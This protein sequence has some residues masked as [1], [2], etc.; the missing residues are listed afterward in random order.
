MIKWLDVLNFA[1]NGNPIPPRRVEKTDTE[2]KE[3]L[4]EEQY[5]ITRT[6][7]TERPFSG[8]FCEALEPGLYECVCCETK[9]FDSAEKFNSKSGWPSFTQPVE[10]EAVKYKKDKSF[11]M[12]RVEAM[13]NVCDA[14]LGHVFPDG[15]PPSELRYCIN[16]ASLKKS[17]LQ[18]V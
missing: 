15:P 9:L 17:E 14:H 7:G 4:T 2:W 3:M 1:A 12:T 6:K 10:I 8:E 18:K 5:Y 13:C 11:G 16:S